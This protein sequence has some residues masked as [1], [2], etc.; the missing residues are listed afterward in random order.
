[1]IEACELTKRFGDK[2]V[3][4]RL[5]FTIKI[6]TLGQLRPHCEWMSSS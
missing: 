2:T 1:M 6:D 4:D 3:V 5:S